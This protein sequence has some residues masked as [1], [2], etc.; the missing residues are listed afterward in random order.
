MT[1]VIETLRRCSRCGFLCFR[2]A[3]C[4]TCRWLP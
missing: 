1:A 4:R 3:E 2:F